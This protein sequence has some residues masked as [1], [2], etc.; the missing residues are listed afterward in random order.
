MSELLRADGRLVRVSTLLQVA[1][2]EALTG[3]IRSGANVE[4]AFHRGD[5]VRARAGAL[6]GLAAVYESFVLPH[7]QIVMERADVEAGAPLGPLIAM[8]VEGSRLFDEWERLSGMTFTL[9]GTLPAGTRPE[10][11]RV[12]TRSEGRRTLAALVDIYGFTRCPLVD[13]L[14]GLIESGVLVAS[15][16]SA[17]GAHTAPA[18]SGSVQRVMEGSARQPRAEDDFDTLMGN[19]RAQVRAGRYDLARQQFEAALRLRPQDPTVRQNL[20]RLDQLQGDRFA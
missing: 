3:R 4:I 5:V 9:A 12:A 19:A 2:L 11:Q 7:E 18:E 15:T 13:P 17:S 10:V 20:R 16:G 8:I 1:D 6:S 14:L